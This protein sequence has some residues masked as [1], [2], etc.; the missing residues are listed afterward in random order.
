MTL[1]QQNNVT[2]FPY[3]IRGQKGKETYYENACGIWSKAEYNA[4]GKAT[5]SEYSNG[6]WVKREYDANGKLTYYETSDG[7]LIDDRPK[8]VN[9]TKV[10]VTI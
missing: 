1:A 8:K 5:Y 4:N 2:E 6:F 9:H 7:I 3:I 10:Q